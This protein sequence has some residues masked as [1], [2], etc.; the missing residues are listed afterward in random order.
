MESPHKIAVWSDASETGWGGHAAQ[1]VANGVSSPLEA[2]KKLHLEIAMGSTSHHKGIDYGL[3][4]S[5]VC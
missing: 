5:L 1:N 4:K 2:K 3:S